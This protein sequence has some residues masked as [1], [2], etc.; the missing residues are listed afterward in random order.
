[1]M[2]NDPTLWPEAVCLGACSAKV[3]KRPCI[4]LNGDRQELRKRMDCRTA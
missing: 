1:M 2:P 4:D 3:A